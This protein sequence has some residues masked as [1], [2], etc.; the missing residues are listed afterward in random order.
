MYCF[1]SK[2]NRVNRFITFQYMN[3]IS[4]V[5]REMINVLFRSK[6][7]HYVYIKLRS[8]FFTYI[9]FYVTLR[10]CKPTPTHRSGRELS[11]DASA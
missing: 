2:G 8:S 6:P 10:P 1:I 9:H 7:E 4:T 3:Y 11:D 5:E